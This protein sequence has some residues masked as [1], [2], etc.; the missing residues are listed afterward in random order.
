MLT[1]SGGL[2]LTLP[3]PQGNPGSTLALAHHANEDKQE[4]NADETVFIGQ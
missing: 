2:A 1:P 4:S 3:P